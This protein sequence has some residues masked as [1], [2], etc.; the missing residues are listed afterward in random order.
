[1]KNENTVVA[2]EIE[3]LY[4]EIEN[5]KKVVDNNK[6]VLFELLEVLKN[7]EIPYRTK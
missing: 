6:D 7:A 3:N 5:L 1:M 2:A 4:R